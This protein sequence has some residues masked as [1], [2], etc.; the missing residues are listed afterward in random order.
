MFFLKTQNWYEKNKKKQELNEDIRHY[1]NAKNLIRVELQ[2]QERVS[3]IME[4]KDVRVSDLFNP[5]FCKLLMK[6]WLSLY[7]SI[8]KEALPDYPKSFKG[9]LDFEKFIKRLVIK[10][11]GWER[12]NF[13]MRTAIKQKSLSA[14]DK[15]KKLK[16]FRIT[17][18]DNSNFEFQEHT[19][20]LNHKVKVMYVESLKQIYKLK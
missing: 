5:D 1:T 6:K 15:S 17:M 20:E 10:F 9:N 13:I 18:L 7:Q 19:L 2:I 14:S 4:V 11:L 16:Q 12:L 3:Q 8:F